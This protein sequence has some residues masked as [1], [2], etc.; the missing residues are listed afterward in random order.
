M[1]SPRPPFPAIKG[2]FG[3]PTNINNVETLANIP[4]IMTRGGDWFAS[5]GT[6]KSKGT[7]VFAIA[8]KIANAGLIEIP[9]GMPLRKIVEEIGAAF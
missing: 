6:E 9:M 1:P 8:G 2:L 7:K 4:V 5:M 3:K